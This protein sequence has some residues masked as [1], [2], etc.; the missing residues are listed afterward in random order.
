MNGGLKKPLTTQVVR[1]AFHSYYLQKNN[2][3][4]HRNLQA[5]SDLRV[6]IQWRSGT[7]AEIRKQTEEKVLSVMSFKGVQV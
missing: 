3:N 6:Y 1:R 5:T 7:L 4:Q 2:I